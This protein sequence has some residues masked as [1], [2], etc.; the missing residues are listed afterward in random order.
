MVRAQI[1]LT[2]R[3]LK[4]DPLLSDQLIVGGRYEMASGVIDVIA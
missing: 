2:V 3:Q 4:R 1:R